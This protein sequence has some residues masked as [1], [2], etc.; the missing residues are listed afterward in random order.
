M[1]KALSH[2]FRDRVVAA[3]EGGLSDRAA[4]ARF[5]VGLSSAI[6]WHQLARKHGRA[7]DGKP[8]GDQRSLKIE[9]VRNL[10]NATASRPPSLPTRLEPYSASGQR[11]PY[12]GSNSRITLF[13]IYYRY[14]D[15]FF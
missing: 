7:I 9:A 3:I 5:V 12:R 6:R 1:S 4:S 10:P 15:C 2:D 11:G 14:L 8:G 13:H